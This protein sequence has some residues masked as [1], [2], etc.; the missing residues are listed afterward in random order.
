MEKIDFKHAIPGFTNNTDFIYFIFRS[1][2]SLW[3]LLIERSTIPVEGS[4]SIAS[5]F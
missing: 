2:D 4:I 5:Q 1:R 3:W